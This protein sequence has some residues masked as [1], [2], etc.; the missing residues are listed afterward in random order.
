MTLLNTKHIKSFKLY[1]QRGGIVIH[2]LKLTSEHM[3]QGLRVQ[4]MVLCARQNTSLCDFTKFSQSFNMNKRT[5]NS[6]LFLCF[7]R[8]RNRSWE[9]L[10]NLAKLLWHICKE[11]W[12]WAQVCGIHTPD[13]HWPCGI[14]QGMII[15]ITVHY[16]PFDVEA[17]AP[18]QPK[19]LTPTLG[20]PMSSST[21][22]AHLRG[23]MSLRLNTEIQA[24]QD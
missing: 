1:R 16:F 22:V 11:D 2:E 4:E 3:L 17:E 14:S 19:L 18:T 12:A 10:N 13:F 23:I 6:F 5:V 9:T 8:W 7:Y 20:R 24:E 15:A 21:V